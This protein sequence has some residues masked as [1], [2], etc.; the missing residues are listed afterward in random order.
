ME[1]EKLVFKKFK[2]EVFF[3]SFAQFFDLTLP[4]IARRWEFEIDLIFFFSFLLLI[5]ILSTATAT[6]TVTNGAKTVTIW[7]RTNLYDDHEN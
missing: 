1:V 2:N 7:T 5:L 4:L 3:L 6:M